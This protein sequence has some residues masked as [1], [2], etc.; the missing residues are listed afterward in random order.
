MTEDVEV[1]SSEN[2]IALYKRIKADKTEASADDYKAANI[3]AQVD[4]STLRLAVAMLGTWNRA[5]IKRLKEG[6]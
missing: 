2:I 5:E 3:A 1:K 4:E 6:A